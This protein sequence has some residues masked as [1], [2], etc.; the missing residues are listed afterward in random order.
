MPAVEQRREQLPRSPHEI[1][2]S[3]RAARVRRERQDERV[4]DRHLHAPADALP[5]PSASRAGLARSEP[6]RYFV[7][8]DQSGAFAESIEQSVE[9]AYQRSVLQAVGRYVRQNLRAQQREAID[10]SAVPADVGPPVI[11]PPSTPSSQPAARTPCSRSSDRCSPRTRP[12]SRRRP[13][14][15]RA[16]T[17][18]TASTP[19]RAWRR[20]SPRSGPI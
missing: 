9:C 19:A 5:S 2:A 7:V 13:A 20:S 14:R 15:S 18:P 1:H 8:V 10:L 12:S 16:S 6:S 3:D 17:C 11:R 4:L